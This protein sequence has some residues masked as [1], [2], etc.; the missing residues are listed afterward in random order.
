MSKKALIYCDLFLQMP[1]NKL[2]NHLR[3]SLPAV[4]TKSV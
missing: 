2:L 3:T 1:G 4:D